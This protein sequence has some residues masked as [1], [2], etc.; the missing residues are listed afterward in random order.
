MDSKL[1]EL[2]E[3]KGIR[4]RQSERTARDEITYNSARDISQIDFLQRL[5]G[6]AIY[7][8]I[9]CDQPF[10][11]FYTNM[12]ENIEYEYPRTLLANIPFVMKD[13][14]LRAIRIEPAAYPATF[15]FFA[16]R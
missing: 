5:N 7:F 13:E 8:D 11:L 10:R 6:P 16:S 2:F 1:Q 12:S 15:T 4:L 9:E 14:N 3:E